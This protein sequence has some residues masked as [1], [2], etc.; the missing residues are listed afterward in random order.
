MLSSKIIIVFLLAYQTKPIFQF[1]AIKV[2]LCWLLMLINFT[3]QDI[4]VTIDLHPLYQEW[5]QRAKEIIVT[6]QLIGMHQNY[7]LQAAY[8]SLKLTWITQSIVLI[9]SL[10]DKNSSPQGAAQGQS[11]LLLQIVILTINLLLIANN[12]IRQCRKHFSW[13][14]RTENMTELRQYNRQ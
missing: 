13:C 1:K 5:N 10:L 2:N 3:R 6:V 9:M 8:Q 11:C 12:S 14:L 4:R 7:Y